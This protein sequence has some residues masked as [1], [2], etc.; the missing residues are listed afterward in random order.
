MEE[1][2]DPAP[3]EDK[4]NPPTTAQLLHK[5]YTTINCPENLKPKA[6]HKNSLSI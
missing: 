5:I 2:S 1:A 4:T 3:N 6:P